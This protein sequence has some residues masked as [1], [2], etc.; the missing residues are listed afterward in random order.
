MT[1]KFTK[2]ATQINRYDLIQILAGRT[3]EKKYK[4]GSQNNMQGYTIS[5][6]KIRIGCKNNTRWCPKSE[7]FTKKTNACKDMKSTYKSIMECRGNTQESTRKKMQREP[8]PKTSR[9]RRKSTKL[10]GVRLS[11]VKGVAGENRRI[12]KSNSIPTMAA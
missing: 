9:N 11:Y 5:R 3:I 10:R 7:L 8:W 1:R 4:K 12:N 6:R 2:E